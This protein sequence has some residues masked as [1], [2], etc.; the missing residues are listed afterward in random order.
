[1]KEI[2]FKGESGE[3]RGRNGV[4]TPRTADCFKTTSGK[5]MLSIWS[6]RTDGEPAIYIDLEFTEMAKLA[7]L[8]SECVT[9]LK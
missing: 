9:E 2:K 8:L 7:K 5:L 6:R 3:A 4:F 1:M